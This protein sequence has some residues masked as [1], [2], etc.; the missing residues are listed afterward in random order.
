MARVSACGQRDVHV[1]FPLR[2]VLLASSSSSDSA[3]V[4]HPGTVLIHA[5]GRLSF[6]THPLGCHGHV[7]NSHGTVSNLVFVLIDDVM[8]SV[9]DLHVDT[10]PMPL[11]H[12]LLLMDLGDIMA[13]PGNR[14]TTHN[15]TPGASRAKLIHMANDASELQIPG[16][17]FVS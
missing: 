14:I 10:P 15:L 9:P 5:G 11:S 7:V 8:Y 4:L 16:Q 17:Q 13:C 3:R 2:L 6:K 1:C 12:R